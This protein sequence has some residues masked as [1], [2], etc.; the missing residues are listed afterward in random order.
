MMNVTWKIALLCAAAALTAGC[1]AAVG[2]AVHGAKAKS[3]YDD[4]I[5]A[6]NKGDKVAQFKVGDALCCEVDGQT[7]A[8][9]TR[10]SVEYLC[11]SAAQ[12]YAP[13][14]Y[15]L[16]R[17]YSGD[18]V[19]GVRLLR[20]AAVAATAPTNPPIAYAWFANA[21]AHGDKD[22]DDAV[23]DTWKGMTPQQQEVAKMQTARG[24]NATCRWD[25]AMR[26]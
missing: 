11:K 1:A 3:Q 23:T 8:Y 15:K 18:T 9:D 12:G 2:E 14:M 20:R 4:N 19:S 25:E 5:D 26:K 22:A 13:A 24:L 21:K 10:R 17:I 7:G 6:A 16:G